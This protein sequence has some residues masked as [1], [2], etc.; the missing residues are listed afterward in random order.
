MSP[1]TEHRRIRAALAVALFPAILTGVALEPASGSG[2]TADRA[3]TPGTAGSDERA[4]RGHGAGQNAPRFNDWLPRITYSCLPDGSTR[5][6]LTGARIV[7]FTNGDQRIKGFQFKYRLV[8]DGT[9]GQPVPYANWSNNAT[10]SFSQGSVRT[11]WMNAGQL[12]QTHSTLADW[13]IELK[14]KYPRSLRTAFRYKYRRNLTEPQCGVIAP[15]AR[16]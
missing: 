3:D 8:P 7:M 15:E 5:F 11:T 10:T 16:A 12:G 1:I 14:L 13:D 2:R 9:D 4:G 6:R